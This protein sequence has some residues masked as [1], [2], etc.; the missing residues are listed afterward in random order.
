MGAE[1]RE[2]FRCI[3]PN[4]DSVPIFLEVK[5]LPASVGFDLFTKIN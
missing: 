3:L 5:D 1:G 4:D 2:K